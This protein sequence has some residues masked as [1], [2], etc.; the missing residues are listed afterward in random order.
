MEQLITDTIVDIISEKNT[1]AYEGNPSSYRKGF[2]VQKP[3]LVSRTT[4][5]NRRLLVNVDWIEKNINEG[6]R[7]VTLPADSIV[8]PEAKLILDERKIRVERR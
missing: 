1:G 4:F 5:K 3:Y 7:R 6:E 8:T 2:F